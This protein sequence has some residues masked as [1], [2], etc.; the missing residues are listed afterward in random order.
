MRKEIVLVLLTVVMAILAG[1]AFSQA[2]I[3]DHTC[4]DLSQIP[5]YWLNQAK[6]LQIHYA[7]TSH[8]GQIISGIETLEGQHSKYAVAVED[9]SL[10]TTSGAICIF[11]GQEGFTYIEPDDYWRTEDGRDNTRAVLDNNPTID[12][13]MWAWC[14]QVSYYPTSDI[15]NYLSVMNQFESEYSPRRFIYMTGHLDG[16]GSGG[17][18]NTHNN[19]IRNYCVANGKV[20]YDFADIESYDPDGTGYLDQGGGT[21]GEGDGCQYDYGNWG[22][23]W[24]AA[25]PGSDLCLT[26]SCAHSQPLNCNLKGRAFWWMMA[27]LAGWDGSSAAPTPTPPGSSAESGIDS[28]DYNGD[29]TADLAVFRSSSGLWAVRGVSRLYFGGSSDIPS[30]GDYNGD[31]TTDVGLYRPSSGLWA[32]SEVTRIYFGGSSDQPIPSDYDG[33]GACDPGIFRPS[34]GLWAV[35]GITRTYFGSSSDSAV[36]GDYNG[37]GTSDIGL[38]RSSSGLW[39]IQGVTRVYF[40]GSSDSPVAGDYSGGGGRQIG[41]FRASSGLWA[42]R[43]VTRIY[44][45]GSSDTPVPADY[46]GDGSDD[47]GIFRSASGLWAISDL[48]RAYFGSGGDIPVVR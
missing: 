39:A 28:G 30:P 2:I 29:G 5:E 18:L 14:G 24:C 31:G 43:G 16:S 1:S 3:I 35:T 22:T 32:I 8:G 4:T 17:T 44:F 21:G 20:L 36:S 42:I 40:G 33:D 13:S 37:D 46:N 6:N 23:E 15:N 11:D 27:R 47:T 38:Y 12:F 34:S 10:P 48:T 7:H 41:I 19:I 9:S 26:C 45:G 25:H